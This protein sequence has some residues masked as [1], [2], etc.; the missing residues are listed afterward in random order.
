MSNSLEDNGIIATDVNF[1]RVFG[2]NESVPCLERKSTSPW[3]YQ[4][5][6]AIIQIYLCFSHILDLDLSNDFD[7]IIVGTMLALHCESLSLESNNLKDLFDSKNL[8]LLLVT[9][10]CEFFF[11]T[12]VTWSIILEI[13]T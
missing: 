3:I 6:W 11:L 4:D 12:G 8:C 7:T 1:S 9:C 10:V 2:E 5:P 13:P